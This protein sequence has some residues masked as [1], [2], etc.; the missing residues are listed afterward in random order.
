MQYRSVYRLHRYPE[1]R[2]GY[3]KW[4]SDL[5]R[6]HAQKAG[7]ILHVVGYDQGIIDRVQ[8]II[9]KRKL[10]IDPELQTI[11]DALCLV[12]L[13]LQY[14]EFIE[15][16]SD[17]KIIRILR[18]TWGKMTDRGRKVALTLDFSEKGTLLLSKAL[19][20]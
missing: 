12:F 8:E 13:E 3:L 11:E 17:E 4:R 20:N 14:D 15:K 5:A 9:L 2:V 10:K 6:F 1:G 19:E 16:H 7:D 18:K